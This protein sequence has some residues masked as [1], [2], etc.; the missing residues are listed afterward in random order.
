MK[1][2]PPV[3]L[4]VDE[5]QLQAG[6]LVAAYL[7]GKLTF[8][9]VNAKLAPLNYTFCSE[10]FAHRPTGHEDHLRDWRLAR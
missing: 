5:P 1:K 10:C 7:D 8:E 6:R 2:T 3:E 4:V 9:E